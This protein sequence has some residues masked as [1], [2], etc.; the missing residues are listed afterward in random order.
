MVVEVEEEGGKGEAHRV[1]VWQVG[2]KNLRSELKFGR[3]IRKFFGES[4]LASELAAFIGS[5]RRPINDDVP[6]Q[7]IV[8]ARFVHGLQNFIRI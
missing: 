2:V 6:Q 7:H 1:Y 8:L 4:Q 3:L 5:A